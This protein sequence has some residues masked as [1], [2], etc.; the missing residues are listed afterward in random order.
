LIGIAFSIGFV[1]GPLI[2]AGFSIWAKQQ[3]GAF[4]TVPALFALTLSVIDILFVFIFFKETLP[5]EKRVSSC[6]S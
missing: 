6:R 4:Y 5:A 1:F 2:G 3:H